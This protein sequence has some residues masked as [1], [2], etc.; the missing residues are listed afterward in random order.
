M[1]IHEE[2]KGNDLTNFTVEQ[3]KKC[4]ILRSVKAPWSETTTATVWPALL[5]PP[6]KRHR[7]IKVVQ[8]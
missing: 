5:V 6:R 8:K 4:K 3:R 2:K 1:C 7:E